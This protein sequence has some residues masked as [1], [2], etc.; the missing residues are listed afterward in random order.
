MVEDGYITEGTSSA[1][2]LVVD[3]DCLV[4]RP[5]TNAVLDSITRRAIL[6]LASRTT[7]TT[8]ERKFTVNDAF[9]ANEV[10][11]ASATALITPIIELDGKPIGTGSPGPWV[12]RLRQAYLD[13]ASNGTFEIAGYP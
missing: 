11:V 13:I 8:V 6:S 12:P 7:L 5:V 9:Q 1:V 2:G 3:G 10:F 4:T